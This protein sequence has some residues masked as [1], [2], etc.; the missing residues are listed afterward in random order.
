MKRVLF[1]IAYFFAILFYN[2]GASS[3]FVDIFMF[4]YIN[5][6]C[7]HVLI[8]IMQIRGRKRLLP[9]TAALDN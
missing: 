6:V 5:C 3:I 2:F 7:F 9:V 1:D 4:I 8:N